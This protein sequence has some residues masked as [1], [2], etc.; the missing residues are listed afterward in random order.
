VAARRNEML[1]H[2]RA[3]FQGEPIAA[4]TD[5]PSQEAR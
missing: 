2:C 1:G 4:S 5:S 3:L